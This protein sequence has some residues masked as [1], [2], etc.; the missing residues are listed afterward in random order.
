MHLVIL[1]VAQ[2]RRDRPSSVVSLL[3][4]VLVL[5]VGDTIVVAI[6]G[7]YSFDKFSTTRVQAVKSILHGMKL[8]TL[9]RLELVEDRV[10]DHLHA[11][12][13]VPLWL[14]RLH[15]HTLHFVS[16]LIGRTHDRVSIGQSLYHLDD[17]LW[18]EVEQRILG[19]QS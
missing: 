6:D 5:A 19:R 9:Q 12:F 18:T 3:Q 10:P 4:S 11:H 8:Q 16:M 15:H 1:V 13:V 2:R 17:W 14:D 7:G